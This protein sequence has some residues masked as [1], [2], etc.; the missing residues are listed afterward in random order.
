MQ[1][2]IKG[3]I[4]GEIEVTNTE[5][6]NQVANFRIAENKAFHNRK[7]GRKQKV[8]KFYSMKAWNGVAASI[9]K[10]LQKGDLVSFKVDVQP[11][12][13]TATDGQ[14]K[15]EL[16]MTVNRFRFIRASRRNTNN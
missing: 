6:G 14:T 4:T 8:T 9:R 16:V 10:N 15:S 3:R 13:W 1:K 7:T 5:N 2:I 12:A 11:N